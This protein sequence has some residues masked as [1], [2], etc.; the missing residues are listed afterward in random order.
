MQRT[1]ASGDLI[2]ALS[3]DDR[4]VRE[5]AC[6]GLA[7]LKCVE[8][9]GAILDLYRNDA[10]SNV[11]QAATVALCAIG[12]PEAEQAVQRTSVLTGEMK[13]IASEMKDF[14]EVLSTLGV[15]TAR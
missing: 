14:K 2:E 15:P 8:A 6:L 4:L 10:I 12:G 1:E 9:T 13:A 5:A 7:K 3:D 11:R